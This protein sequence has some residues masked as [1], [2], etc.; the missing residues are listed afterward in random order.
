[1]YCSL[2]WI[3]NDYDNKV[4]LDFRVL[5][6]WVLW[7]WRGNTLNLAR[8][9]SYPTYKREARLNRYDAIFREVLQ[10]CIFFFCV[11]TCIKKGLVYVITA[12]QIFEKKKLKNGLSSINVVLVHFYNT[13]FLV[14][15]MTSIFP[16]QA[17]LAV[18]DLILAVNKDTLL[19]STYDAVST[20][21][22]CK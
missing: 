1:M 2:K 22:E 16:L 11:F 5:M 4:T 13:T 7:F 12:V 6:A 17:G 19:G 3:N 9:Y 10:C 15:N 20:F 21:N 14:P 18:G 8:V